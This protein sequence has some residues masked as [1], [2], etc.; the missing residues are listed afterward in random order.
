MRERQGARLA[1]AAGVGRV[2]RDA[3]ACPR[4]GL[5]R[6]HELVAEHERPSHRGIADRA[7]GEPVP[8]GAAQA[9]G[10]HAQEQLAL[11]RLGRLF[12]AEAKVADTVQ[13]EGLHRWP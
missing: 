10:L 9:D 6:R 8:V 2:D 1:N 11:A 7:L 3:L 12:V 4:S 13:P 5:D